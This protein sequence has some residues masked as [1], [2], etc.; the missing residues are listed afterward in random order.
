MFMNQVF[1]NSVV[2]KIY[3]KKTVNVL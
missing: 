2:H 1:G 3:M